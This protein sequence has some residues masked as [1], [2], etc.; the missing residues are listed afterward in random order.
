MW[1]LAWGCRFEGLAIYIIEFPGNHAKPLIRD[2]CA[3][4]APTL[5]EQWASNGPCEAK[6]F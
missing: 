1:F 2:A 6:Q 3:T 4:L 5:K